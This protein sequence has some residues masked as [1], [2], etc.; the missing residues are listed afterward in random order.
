MLINVFYGILTASEQQ[1]MG[2][3]RDEF[4]AIPS[5]AEPHNHII[6]QY[7]QNGRRIGS[8]L[9]ASGARLVQVEVNAVPVD[10]TDAAV[11]GDVVRQARDATLGRVFAGLSKP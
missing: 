5:D 1:R 9:N 7:Y 4:V 10:L 6:A 8:Y 3:Q 2:V 11:Y